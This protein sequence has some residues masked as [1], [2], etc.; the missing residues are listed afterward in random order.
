MK[1]LHYWNMLIGLEGRYRAALDQLLK[2]ALSAA[3]E[4]RSVE[5][6]ILHEYA[7][8]VRDN[9]RELRR[10]ARLLRAQADHFFN[11]RIQ[12]LTEEEQKKLA[13]DDGEGMAR[14]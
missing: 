11:G 1:Y 5:R 13:R 12:A 7:V 3:G 14:A 9:A 6:A 10:N 2:A 8:R 4:L